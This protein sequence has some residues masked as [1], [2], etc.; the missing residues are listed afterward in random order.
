MP[1]GYNGF[2][3][4]QKRALEWLP[5]DGSWKTNPGRLTGALNSLALQHPDCVKHEWG[6]FGPR[7]VSILRWR[8]TSDGVRAKHPAK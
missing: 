5:S 3:D 6:S 2:T 1:R 7:G 8:L 4:A